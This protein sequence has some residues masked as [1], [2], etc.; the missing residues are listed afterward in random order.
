VVVDLDLRGSDFEEPWSYGNVS[1][2]YRTSRRVNVLGFRNSNE[3]ALKTQP[4]H[5]DVSE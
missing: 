4:K 5:Q 1:L 2:S 3:T